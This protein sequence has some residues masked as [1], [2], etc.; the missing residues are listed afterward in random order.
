MGLVAPQHVESSRTRDQIHVLCIGR[1]I[2]IHC[3]TWEVL[4]HRILNFVYLCLLLD[5]WHILLIEILI[6]YQNLGQNQ[7]IYLNIYEIILWR[8][9]V[10]NT[11][12]FLPIPLSVFQIL[13][14]AVF[15]PYLGSFRL[16]KTY[17]C[18]H[19]FSGTINDM[20]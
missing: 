20:N 17:Y 10:F 19:S 9:R 1:W 18:C 13:I 16:T 6:T 2:L 4:S 11:I 14:S 5:I 12:S 3:T 15:L 8:S 7:H